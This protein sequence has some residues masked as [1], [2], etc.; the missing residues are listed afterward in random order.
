MPSAKPVKTSSFGGCTADKIRPNPITPE[1]PV[2]NVILSFEET[3]KLKAA[4]DACASPLNTYDRSTTAG[5]RA[6]MCLAVF[7]HQGRVTITE[8]NI[9][10]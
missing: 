2:V 6:G 5:R 10:L 8:Q 4:I 9:G 3:L 7:L 1:T